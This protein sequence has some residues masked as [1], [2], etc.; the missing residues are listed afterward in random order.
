MD[1]YLGEIRMWTC[2]RIP[3]GWQVCDGSTL[4][5]SENEALFSLLGTVWGGDGVTDFGVPDLRGRLPV[6]Q[7]QGTGLTSR[8]MGQTDGAENVTVVETQLPAHNHLI[9]AMTTAATTTTPGSTVTVAQMTGKDSMYSAAGQA[10]QF[11]A[12]PMATATI[13]P[14]GGNVPHSNIMPEL[15]LTFI[16]CVAGIYP[17]RA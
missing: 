8:I 14:F 3:V 6:G 11:R 5:I 12:V 4:S 15:A 16:M 10:N 1:A 9:S 2:P 7:G 13:A 17:Q